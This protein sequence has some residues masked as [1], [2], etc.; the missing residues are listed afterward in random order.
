MRNSRSL[1]SRATSIALTVLVLVGILTLGVWLGGH[2]DRLPGG[3][4]DALVGDQDTRIVDEA[5]GQIHDT[6]YRPVS[7]RELAN[8]SIQ[9]AV[10]SL[11]DRFSAYFD[12][13][14]Y[15]RFVQAQH[16]RYAGVGISVR[17]DRR[18]LRVLEVYDG[19]PARRAGI[20][21]GD[22]IVE[23][24]GTSLAGRGDK[25]SSA[26][27]RGPAGTDVTLKVRHRGQVR[28]VRLVRSSITVPVV[29]SRTIA[30]RGARI[31]VIHLAQFSAGAHGEVDRAVR[32]ALQRGAKGLVFDLRHNGGGLVD[33]ARLVASAFLR[34]GPIVTTRGRAVP[35]KTLTATGDPVAPATPLVVLVDRET[36]SASEIVAGALQDRHRAT[37]VGTHTFGKGVFQQLIPLSNGGALDITAGEYFTPDGRNLGGG[38]VKQG[39]GIAPDVRAKDDPATPRDEALDAAV[40]AVRAKVHG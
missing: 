37:I 15:G 2:P 28:T 24:N 21:P 26:I 34:D 25:S 12:P 1:A 13:T 39:A 33:E 35:A 10:A 23:A 14:D 19:S 8:R 18:G 17:A 20:V 27:I 4:R 38:G 16:Q 29:A 5:I 30:S 32:T 40:Q 9:G 7:E 11:H 36:A 6:Y 22:L 31:G 3:V